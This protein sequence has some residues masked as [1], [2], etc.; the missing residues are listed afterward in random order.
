MRKLIIKIFI[1]I[2]CLNF[3][4]GCRL[5][6]EQRRKTIGS[7]PFEKQKW[8]TSDK[9]T[10]WKYRPKIAR[11]LVNKKLLIGKSRAEIFEMLGENN[12]HEW[13]SGKNIKYELEQI[14][15][16]NID[17][18]AI[19]YLVVTFDNEDKVEKTEI[20]FYKTGE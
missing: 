7:M 10:D 20:Q 1:L 16:T 18:I 9:E 14:Y 15:G 4:F 2:L 8:K 12:N 17:P 5:A 11:D 13:D 19:E 6:I 3:I